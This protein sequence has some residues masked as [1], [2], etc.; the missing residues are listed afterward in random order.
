M[1]LAAR[2]AGFL[3]AALIFAAGCNEDAPETISREAFIET[4]MALRI[5]EL[6]ESGGEV[7]SAEAR[8]RVLDEQGVTEEELFG[9]A[10]V[11]GGDVDFMKE[12]WKEVDSLLTAQREESGG[13]RTGVGGEAG[14]D[15]EASSP[16]SPWTNRAGTGS[17]REPPPHSHSIVAGGF[18]LM[19]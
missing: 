8:E 1:R 12:V 19:S 10:E 11:H 16:Y 7:I 4:Y 18:E 2:C 17:A 9:F 6:S 13:K 5:A 15:P 3:A 14:G